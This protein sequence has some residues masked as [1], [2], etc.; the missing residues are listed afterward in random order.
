[1]YICQQCGGKVIYDIEAGKMRCIYCGTLSPV[2]SFQ[3][4]N[5]VNAKMYE[6]NIFICN[7]C[8]AEISSMDNEIV[9]YCSYCGSQTMLFE[10]TVNSQRP[11]DMIP[12]RL[13]RKAMHSVYEKKFSGIWYLPKEFKDPQYIDSMRGIYMPF[14]AT[15][16]VFAPGSHVQVH[17]TTEL[18]GSK[19]VERTYDVTVNAQNDSRFYTDASSNLDD[20]ITEQLLPYPDN[21]MI[22]FNPAYLAGFYADQADV[23]PQKYAATLVEKASKEVI[24]A[25]NRNL[26]T[27]YTVETNS[28]G[29][30]IRGPIPVACKDYHASLL[31]MWFLTRRDKNRVSYAVANGVNGRI[32]A[33]LPVDSKKYWLVTLGIAAVLFVI[34]NLVLSLTAIKTATWCMLLTS[35]MMFV[36]QGELRTVME[37]E[38]HLFDVGSP[39]YDPIKAAKMKKKTKNTNLSGCATTIITIIIFSVGGAVL[40]GEVDVSPI[41]MLFSFVFALI[42]MIRTIRFGSQIPKYQWLMVAGIFAFLCVLFAFNVLLLKPVMD[43]WYYMAAIACLAGALVPGALMIKCYNLIASH[44]LPEYFRREGGLNDAK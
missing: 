10:K 28:Q 27:G 11:K 42:Q 20:N 30:P 4:K 39:L 17:G 7:S 40:E 8:G 23:P 24:G 12:F 33:D 6:T 35:F 34:L 14:W 2:S 29:E 13:S 15:S 18:G 41:V 22:P 37:R 21:A 3:E 38:L 26:P 32:Y 43:Y 36:Y 44:P 9:S 31:P 16:M 25:I 1:M 19:Y 5:A